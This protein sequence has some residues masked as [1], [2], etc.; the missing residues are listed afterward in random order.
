M[1]DK[2][3]VKL[4]FDVLARATPSK[5]WDGPAPGDL[6]FFLN[7]DN[8]LA[9]CYPWNAKGHAGFQQVITNEANERFT[10]SHH[11]AHTFQ[12]HNTIH[13]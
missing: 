9:F 12:E 2:S 3:E 8:D 13:Q 11:V 5:V 10:N 1:W 4:Q 6:T 7:S